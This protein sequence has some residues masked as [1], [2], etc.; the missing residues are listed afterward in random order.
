M[1]NPAKT[2]T[3]ADSKAIIMAC[4]LGDIDCIQSV[5]RATKLGNLMI[6]SS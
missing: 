6:I 2:E 4:C 5:F 1:V 3:T